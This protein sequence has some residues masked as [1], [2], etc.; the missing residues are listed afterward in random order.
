LQRAIASPPDGLCG[1]LLG[2]LSDK[3]VDVP[4]KSVEGYRKLLEDFGRFC[5]RCIPGGFR[6][7]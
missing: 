6:V 7:Y 2:A 4:E 3:W 5:E 1:A